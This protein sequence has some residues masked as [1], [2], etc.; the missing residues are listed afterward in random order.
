MKD[1]SKN[2]FEIRTNKEGIRKTKKPCLHAGR[3]L[4]GSFKKLR[5]EKTSCCSKM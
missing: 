1:A 3:F 4:C 5:G 2:F